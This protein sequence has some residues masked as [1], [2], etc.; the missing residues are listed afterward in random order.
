MILEL[1]RADVRELADYDLCI[2][3]S[4]PAGA[5]LAAELASKSLR[6]AVLESGVQGRSA[7]GD[8][9][10]ALE[11]EGIHVK[12]WSRERVLGGASTTWSGLS[13]PLDEIDFDSR[14]Y[15]GVE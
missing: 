11:S 10:R 8:R 9:L 13:S 6:I 4:G 3:G 2:V 15:V 1:D 5:T 7:R 12:E 14:P